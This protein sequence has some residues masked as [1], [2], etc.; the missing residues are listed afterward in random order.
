MKIPYKQYN[1]N[2]VT[3]TR[4]LCNAKKALRKK[5]RL[6]KTGTNIGALRVKKWVS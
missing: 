1:S 4:I 2:T 3:V 5:K 6:V